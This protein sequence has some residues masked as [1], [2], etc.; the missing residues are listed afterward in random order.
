MLKL[1][2]NISSRNE[3]ILCLPYSHYDYEI[4]SK[5]YISRIAKQTAKGNDF[6]QAVSTSEVKVAFV[7]VSVII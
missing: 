3:V 6:S 2:D 7:L 5:N 1:K 4:N